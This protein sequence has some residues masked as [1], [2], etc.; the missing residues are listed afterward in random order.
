M[1]IENIRLRVRLSEID[2]QLVHM[3]NP[4]HSRQEETS[5]LLKE[6][7]CGLLE[8]Q[9]TIQE[10]LD[11]IIYPILTIPVEI[12]SEIFLHCLPDQPTQPSARVA[13]LLL[14]AI[15]RQW[16]YIALST[17]RLWAVLKIH[18]P[19]RC[20]RDYN[21]DMV[22][23]WLLR[24]GNMPLSICLILRN[25]RCDCSSDGSQNSLCPTPS[26]LFTDSWERL[27][28]FRGDFLTPIECLEL[29][30]F[31]SNLV[32]CEFHGF[33][34]PC[35]NVPSDFPTLQMTNL[36]SLTLASCEYDEDDPMTMLLGFLTYLTAQVED[37]EL[38][39]EDI[40]PMFNAL[41]SLTTLTLHTDF[42][43]P[44]FAILRL[45]NTSKTFL[46]RVEKITFWV[47]C[48][49][50]WF[51]DVGHDDYGSILVGA[52]TSRSEPRCGV[53]QLM[54]FRF[55]LS[56]SFRWLE[57][58]DDD[59]DRDPP[60]TALARLRELKERGMKIHIGP[61]AASWV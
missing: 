1:K 52:L 38:D 44:V 49:F 42:E 22:Q 40:I 9:K 27:T 3:R 48:H 43:D 16:R 60:A 15:C 30:R 4:A 55:N 23:E 56:S 8:E 2:V 51:Y 32:R 17:P 34:V 33:R 39:D 6:R 50:E 46:P 21:A 11:C 57:D 13:P 24:A 47:R 45:L 58:D 35:D 28:S 37:N 14:S 19:V 41:S 7:Q 18:I 26:S 12:I 59:D 10:S 25:A 31:A 29:L 54:D 36:R 5:G 20:F 61:R 53:A